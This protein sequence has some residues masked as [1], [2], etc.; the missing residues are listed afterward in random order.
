MIIRGMT[1]MSGRGFGG[2]CSFI[3]EGKKKR[4]VSIRTGFL[5]KACQGVSDL[6]RG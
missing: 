4:G 5:V 1:K 2:L 6:Q 3:S